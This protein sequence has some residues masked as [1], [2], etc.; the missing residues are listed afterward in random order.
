MQPPDQP[1]KHTAAQRMPRLGIIAHAYALAIG[2]GLVLDIS[3]ALHVYGLGDWMGQRLAL[4][5]ALLLVGLAV[6]GLALT[7]RAPASAPPVHAGR[8][9]TTRRGLTLLLLLAW[10]ASS[11]NY[12]TFIAPAVMLPAALLL[13]GGAVLLLG[14]LVWLPRPG[15]LLLGA[16]GMG[17]ALRLLS[18]A[19]VAITPSNGDMLPLVQGALAHLLAGQSPYTLYS[20]PWELPLTYAP[21]TWLAYL[22]PYLLA[23]DI[24]LTNLL[25]EVAIGA[26]LL[27]L[28]RHHYVNQN[29]EAAAHPDWLHQPALLLWAWVFLQPSLLNWSLATTA[30]VLWALLAWLLV[31]LVCGRQWAAALLLGLCAAASS[32]TAVAALFVLLHWLRTQ[33]WQ[34]TLWLAGAA[35]STAAVLVLPFLLWAPDD[36]IFGVVR[37]FNDNS[38]YPR[39]RWEL[40]HTWARQTGFSGIFWRRGLEE[41]LKPLQAGLLLALAGLAWWRGAAAWMIAPLVCAAYLLFMV[42]NPV[43]W[44]YLYNPAL[45]AALVAVVALAAAPAHAGLR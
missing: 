24:R 41:L 29:N 6:G 1:V 21:L 23:L 30:P 35:G 15:W 45:I 8:Q 4:G 37:W 32:L 43:L 9:A 13:G 7:L 20:M 10:L 40:D 36:F 38:L 12:V 22:P 11:Y 42:F 2:L 27:F 26:A 34:R 19:H 31:L 44:P 25:A 18:Y 33:G 5:V 14:A 3:G 17:G 28:A 16:L 39:L